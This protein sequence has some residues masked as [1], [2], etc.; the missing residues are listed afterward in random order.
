MLRSGPCSVLISSFALKSCSWW[1]LREFADVGEP[2][3]VLTPTP[4]TP[5]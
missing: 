4:D 3:I 1:A 5:S 2:P